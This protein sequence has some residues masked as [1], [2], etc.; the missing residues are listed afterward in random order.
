MTEGQRTALFELRRVAT[1]PDSALELL[2][3]DEELGRALVSVDCG[4]IPSVPGGL[5]LRARERFEIQVPADFPVCGTNGSRSTYALR[6]IPARA[7]E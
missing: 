1:T 3:V 6:W 4:A 7:V 5:R 2:A